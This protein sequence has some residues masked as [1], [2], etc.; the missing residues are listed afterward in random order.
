LLGKVSKLKPLAAMLALA[1]PQP[2]SA[3]GP[4]RRPVV[5]RPKGRVIMLQGC[6]EPVL[7]PAYQN[8]AA[9]ILARMGYQMVSVAG[10]GC[11]GA[12]VHHMGREEAALEAARRNIDMW[13]AEIAK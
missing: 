8:A 12:L 4:E 13:Q 10:E 9:R 5:D 6:A 2:N 7:R 11:C 1:G 3:G